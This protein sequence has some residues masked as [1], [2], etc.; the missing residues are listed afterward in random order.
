VAEAVYILC[1][2]TSAACAALLV[3][4][5]LA[6]RTAILL[7]S[8]IGFAGLAV[9]NFVLV[10]DMVVLPETDLSILRQVAAVAGLGPMACGLSW[11]ARR[12]VGRPAGVF[13]DGEESWDVRGGE[14]DRP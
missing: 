4:G 9:S 2:L 8:S 6:S 11:G 12:S 5:Y 3:R 13:R 14:G 10:L 1:A 7:W